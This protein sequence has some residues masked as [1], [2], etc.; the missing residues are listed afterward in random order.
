VHSS[1]LLQR[2]YGNR[3]VQRALALGRS[4]EREGEITPG[5]EA[6]IQRA[7]GGGQALDDGVRAQMESAFDADFRGVRVHAD[8]EADTLNRALSARAFT[9]GQEIFFR[10]GEYRPGSSTGKELLAHEL[11]HVVQ[12]NGAPAF[13]KFTV[14]QPEDKEELEAD[15]TAKRVTDILESRPSERE[16]PSLPTD[17]QVG[18]Q[19]AVLARGLQVARAERYGPTIELLQQAVNFATEHP[20]HRLLTR[21]VPVGAS[22][23][24]TRCSCGGIVLPGGECSKCLARRLQRQSVPQR[25][26]RRMVV[27]RAKL[28]RAAGGRTPVQCINNALSSAGIPWAVIA[29]VGVTCGLIGLLGGPAAPATVPLAAAV[30]IGAFS[31]LT[32]GLILGVIIDCLRDPNKEWIFAGA[33]RGGRPGAAAETATA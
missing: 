25:E 27:A 23:V 21:S 31:G 20:R 10:N 18:P 29:L 28:A 7:R 22:P 6:A 26:I 32:V 2:R 3:Y 14:S 8:A 16:T 15:Q 9:T 12:Q 5:V 1:L 19:L 11:A 4:A 13:G 33:E 24:G 17:S 30:C